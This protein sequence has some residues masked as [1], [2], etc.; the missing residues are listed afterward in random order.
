MTEDLS[1]Y[2][3]PEISEQ[4]AET[5]KSL[6]AMGYSPAAISRSLGLDPEEAALFVKVAK[7]PKSR[8]SELIRKG[9]EDFRIEVQARLMN[10]AKD[11]DI[12]AITA[13]EE[14]RNKNRMTNIIDAMDE[15]EFQFTIED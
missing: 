3:G 12:D 13:L 5:V 9:A 7:I 4:Q 1:Q 8:I 14:I 10:N 2:I 15:D 6:A 11:G